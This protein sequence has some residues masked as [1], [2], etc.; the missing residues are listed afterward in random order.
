MNCPPERLFRP[1]AAI[2][3]WRRWCHDNARRSSYDE[4]AASDETVG[5]VEPLRDP[6]K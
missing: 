5:W 6:T 3:A 2:V 4:T 1:D